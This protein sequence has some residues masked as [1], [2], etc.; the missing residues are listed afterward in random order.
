MEMETI[1]YRWLTRLECRHPA[2]APASYALSGDARDDPDVCDYRPKWG[3]HVAP[4]ERQP[5]PVDSEAV[6]QFLRGQRR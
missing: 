3:S 5:P 1:Q 6:A 4:M 2:D